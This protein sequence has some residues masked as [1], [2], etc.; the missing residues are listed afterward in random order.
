[1]G[2]DSGLR[3]KAREALAS[4]GLPRRFPDQTWGGPATGVPCAVCGESTREGEV[5]LGYDSPAPPGRYFVHPPCLAVLEVELEVELA[6]QA[7]GAAPPDP[8]PT[9]ADQFRGD[10]LGAAE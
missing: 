4:G 3:S 5:E 8:L 1:M 10:A 6:V 9:L 2:D 7:N